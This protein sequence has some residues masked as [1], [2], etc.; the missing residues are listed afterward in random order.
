MKKT[1]FSSKL[2]AVALCVMLAA[3]LIPATGLA[4]DSTSNAP[5]SMALV[6]DN[7]FAAYEYNTIGDNS[8]LDAYAGLME[9]APEGSEF[10]IVTPDGTASLTGLAA[11]QEALYNIPLFTST[12]ASA[13]SLLTEA[14]QALS[15]SSGQKMVVLST[16]SCYNNSELQSQMNALATQGIDVRVVAFEKDSQRI[17]AVE[18]AY[19][20]VVV[21]R[22]VRELPLLLGDWYAELAELPAAPVMQPNSAA[23]S[24]GKIYNSSFRTNKHE[25]KF[26]PVEFPTG[27]QE[28]DKLR[29]KNGIALSELLNIY[30]FLPSWATSDSGGYQITDGITCQWIGKGN[31]FNAFQTFSDA[32]SL[33]DFWGNQAELLLQSDCAVAYDPDKPNDMRDIVMENLKRRMPVLAFT[34]ADAYLIYSYD[35]STGKL[36]L[37]GTDGNK[38]DGYLQNY[39]F[40]I[41][42]TGKYFN[43]LRSGM[44]LSDEQSGSANTKTVTISLPDG[45]TDA[46]ESVQ[47]YKKTED[48]AYE[49]MAY[50]SFA[51]GAVSY[52]A[53]QDAEFVVSV[54]VAFDG[55]TPNC[56]NATRNYIIKI[57]PDVSDGQW[58][59]G[60]VFDMSNKGYLIGS[61]GDD[62]V[63]RFLP[64]DPI[65][66]AEFLTVIYRAADI[67]NIEPYT[68]QMASHALQEQWINEEQYQQVLYGINSQPVPAGG[69][70]R[71]IRREEAADILWK[72]FRSDEC[73]VP[74]Q[75]YEYDLST[76][77]YR[78][79]A[80]EAY[81]DKNFS[82]TGYGDSFHQLFLNGVI[83]GSDA[84]TLDPGGNLT[85]AQACKIVSKALY[86]L[87]E[88]GTTLDPVWEENYTELQLG[89]AASGELSAYGGMNYSVEIG[90]AGYYMVSTSAEKYALCDAGGTR[91]EPVDAVNGKDVYMVKSAQE[92]RLYTAGESGAGVTATVEKAPSGYI[93]PQ[94]VVFEQPTEKVVTVKD[95]NG[96]DKEMLL[97]H[98]LIFDDQPEHVRRC[99]ILDDGSYTPR[100]LMHVENLGPGVY[101]V[102]SYHHKS[103]GFLARAGT[104]LD[105]N[106]P[107]YFDAAFYN[108]PGKYGDVQ[109]TRLGYSSNG[110]DRGDTWLN[111]FKAWEEYTNGTPV[112]IN[113]SNYT[114]IS[115]DKTKWLRDVLWEMYPGDDARNSTRISSGA[116]MGYSMLMM[117]FVVTSGS[118][119][120]AT[121]AYKDEQQGHAVFDDWNQTG[122]IKSV[123]EP[124]L[125]VNGV[126]ETTTQVIGKEMEYVIDDSAGTETR[127]PVSI[128]NRLFTNRKSS[129]FTTHMT[130]MSANNRWTVPGS[131]VVELTYHAEGVARTSST[132]AEESYGVRDWKFD[133]MHPADF[134]KAKG[135]YGDLIDED[136]KYDEA[137]IKSLAEP[138]DY[139]LHQEGDE[140]TLASREETFVGFQSVDVVHSY[141]D[142]ASQTFVEGAEVT[143]GMTPINTGYGLTYEY[144][145][146]LHNTGEQ[147]KTF[148]YIFEGRDYHID[149]SVNGG[150]RQGKDIRQ[151]AENGFADIIGYDENDMPIYDEKCWPEE[152]FCIEL[153]P[154][155]TTIKIWVEIMTGSNPSCQNAFVINADDSKRKRAEVVSYDEDGNR[156]TLYYGM[157]YDMEMG[158]RWDIISYPYV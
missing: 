84:Q 54:R 150:A 75:L 110:R 61:T 40:T 107:I 72:A 16:A 112:T 94:E 64:D 103:D 1:N 10:A 58:F 128:S 62:G 5:L 83:A 120:F 105:R 153:P 138:D 99:D 43:L 82:N 17:A 132:G 36:G 123:N 148:S 57:Y 7:S 119:N 37:F 35:E 129:F 156:V 155:E 98:Y 44:Y 142:E 41:V 118:V 33:I 21:C 63:V 90:Q 114:N 141:W 53:G 124:L 45:Y 157:R 42:D 97:P 158:D 126:G 31:L 144:T 88:I 117:E 108:S 137:W 18:A 131:S 109:V 59:A 47:S 50:T 93:A 125:T 52:Q 28:A 91:M 146:K 134:A 34:D 130:E 106:Q 151:R 76:T 6:I 55:I 48:S 11:A 87:S 101:T 30:Y 2:L 113:Y 56:Y 25:Y 121:V 139:L 70:I 19:G 81:T 116:E 96:N 20:N 14:A 149:W 22:D 65:N 104:V 51:N 80:W 133:G 71:P 66:I 8:W 38:T 122:S 29:I 127:L 95:T 140:D 24:S 13:A 67:A 154:G 73:R 3:G 68:G 147:P 78:K 152:V 12:E 86:S 143:E 77:E 26:L 74:H 135:K 27:V 102:F 79:E 145:L 15:G 60:Y 115:I 39:D 4:L 100:A 9:Q 92:L 23:N 46:D 89:T 69:E 49:T 32:Q 85:R 111:L 136:Y